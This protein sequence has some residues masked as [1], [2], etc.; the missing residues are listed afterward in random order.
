MAKKKTVNIDA[1]GKDEQTVPKAGLKPGAWKKNVPATGPKTTNQ[2][3]AEGAKSARMTSRRDRAIAEGMLTGEDTLKVRARHADLIKQE[4]QDKK[5]R[6]AEDFAL[7]GK[8]TGPKDKETY[9]FEDSPTVDKTTSGEIINAL[10][11]SH[12]A[13]AKFETS[14]AGMDAGDS[15]IFTQT[16]H[17]T[18]TPEPTGRATTGGEPVMTTSHQTTQAGHMAS[19]RQAHA[20]GNLANMVKHKQALHNH[21]NKYGWTP[22]GSLCKN[23]NCGNTVDIEDYSPGNA[24]PEHVEKYA[25]AAAGEA[26]CKSCAASGRG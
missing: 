20:E 21:V 10:P 6:E 8:T 9:S 18:H 19:F 24:A 11:K 3:I 4:L 14:G 23:D 12:K 7:T 13:A 16:G 2:T 1:L 17:R 5:D 25:D 22:V 26:P 15:Y